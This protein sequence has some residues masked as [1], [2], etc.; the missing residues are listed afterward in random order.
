MSQLTATSNVTRDFEVPANYQDV[1]VLDNVVIYRASAVGLSA[2]YARQL[3]A[4]D[5]F[6]G[7]AEKTAD[8]TITGHA[9]GFIFCRVRREG[10]VKLAVTS[11]AA[12][13][14]GKPVFASD[15]N[16]F[17]LTESTNSF[18]GYVQRFISSGLAI[19]R[20]EMLTRVY[21]NASNAA[22]VEVI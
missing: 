20:F 1:P 11:V 7:F 22:T 19:V 5:P 10:W 18:I 17:V 12:T 21:A 9:N 4:G 16:T 6:L 2:G 13:D 8:N 14:L 3:V 15:G